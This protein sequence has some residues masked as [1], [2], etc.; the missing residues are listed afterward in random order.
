VFAPR[1]ILE[2]FRDLRLVSFA[3]VGV[4]GELCEDVDPLTLDGSRD[5]VGLFEFT[6]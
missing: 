3:T 4:Q 5:S 1:T 6:K 2:A